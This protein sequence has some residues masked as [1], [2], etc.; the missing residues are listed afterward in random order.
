M[1]GVPCLSIRVVAIRID[2]ISIFA[3]GRHAAHS[4]SGSIVF[5]FPIRLFLNLQIGKLKVARLME[6]GV[7]VAELI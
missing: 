5:P 4:L 3:P 1:S 7:R 2:R 6:I